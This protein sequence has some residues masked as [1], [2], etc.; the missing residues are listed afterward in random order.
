MNAIILAAGLGS[1]F[2]DIT[3]KTHKALLPILGE[4]N[5]ERTIKYLRE[6]NI[7][8]IYIVTGHLSEQFSYLKDKY[9]C[10]ILYNEKYSEYNS[11][12]SF[13]IARE[14]FNDSYVIDADVVLFKNIFL[15]SPRKSFYFVIERPYSDEKE[16]IPELDN[17]KKIINIK[18]SNEVKPSLLGVSYWQKKDCEKI[19]S[20][21]KNY[22]SNDLLVNSKLYWDNI[23]MNIISD[24]DVTTSL[25]SLEDG[26]EM[27]KWE[28][29]QFIINKINKEK[30]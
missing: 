22:L 7:N 3:R 2:K 26:Y 10:H 29:Y 16:W 24:L 1:R 5:I 13:H 18:V 8:D 19:K 4:P 28:H 12:Y 15:K 17:N 23:P 14:I 30:L 27:D 11:I 21:L 20:E 25:I 9:G 6:A